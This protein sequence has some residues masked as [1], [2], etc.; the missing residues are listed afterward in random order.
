[1]AHITGRLLVKSGIKLSYEYCGKYVNT[2]VELSEAN[3]RSEERKLS[4][5]KLEV[6]YCGKLMYCLLTNIT[7][8]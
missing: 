5:C 7:K 2:Y 8:F 6:H 4:G 3:I 1:M